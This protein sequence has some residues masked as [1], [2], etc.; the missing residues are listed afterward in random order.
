MKK[1]TIISILMF[2][3]LL[4]SSC[5]AWLDV[6][7]TNEKERED[8][9]STVNGFRSALIGCYLNLKDQSLYGQAM[10]MTTVEYLA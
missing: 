8:Q 9:F 5:N 7:P 2:A 4:T 1:S 3:I 6:K 10:T